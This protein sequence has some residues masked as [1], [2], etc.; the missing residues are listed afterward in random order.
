MQHDHRF[1]GPMVVLLFQV[2]E[3][4]G[5]DAAAEGEGVG[6]HSGSG[7]CDVGVVEVDGG[8]HMRKSAADARRERALVRA[9]Y[10]VL[11]LDAEVVMQATDAAV[12]RVAAEVARLRGG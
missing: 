3:R 1:V 8:Y 10:A 2:L 5:W 4:A 9:G 12:A 7:R 6:C 11:R